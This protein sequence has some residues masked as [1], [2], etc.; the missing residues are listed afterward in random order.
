MN[1]DELTK[2]KL[3]RQLADREQQVKCMA[4]VNIIVF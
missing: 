3:E 2:K 4:F 1:P